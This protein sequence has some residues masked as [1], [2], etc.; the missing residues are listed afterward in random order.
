[1]IIAIIDSV[2]REQ[3][4]KQNIQRIILYEVWGEAGMIYKGTKVIKFE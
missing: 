1:M 2:R 3:L 4:I